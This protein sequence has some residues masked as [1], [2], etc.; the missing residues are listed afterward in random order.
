[1]TSVSCS[2]QSHAIWNDRVVAQVSAEGASARYSRFSLL[3]AFAI[4]YLVQ[5]TASSFRL[6]SSLVSEIDYFKVCDAFFRFRLTKLS[7]NYYTIT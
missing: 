3:L 6:L 1:M 4:K 5:Y 7:K 2:N